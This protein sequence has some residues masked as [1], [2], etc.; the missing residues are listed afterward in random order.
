MVCE[1]I[2]Y[3]GQATEKCTKAM[4]QVMKYCVG[5]KNHGIKFKPDARWDGDPEF[6]FK[7]MG[8]SNSDYAKDPETQRSISGYSTFLCAAPISTKS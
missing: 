4:L 1:L 3:T 6:E 2:R 5:T 8:K 7:I